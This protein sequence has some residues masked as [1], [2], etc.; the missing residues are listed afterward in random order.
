MDRA[1]VIPKGNACACPSGQIKNNGWAGQSWKAGHCMLCT[2][3]FVHRTPTAIRPTVV[4]CLAR[5]PARGAAGAEAWGRARIEHIK[6]PRVSAAQV[7]SHS[8]H[9][10]TNYAK[11]GAQAAQAC[12]PVLCKIRPDMLCSSLP[13]TECAVRALLVMFCHE[14]AVAV[15]GQHG[16]HGKLQ[17]TMGSIPSIASRVEVSQLPLVDSEQMSRDPASGLWQKLS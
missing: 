7:T 17:P 15:F 10:G 2:M 3:H 12:N 16:H 6:S 1:L 4:P 8:M 9:G 5:R 11:G 14:R 13:Q